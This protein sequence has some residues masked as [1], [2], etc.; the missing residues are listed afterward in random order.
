M[1]ASSQQQLPNTGILRTF[2]SGRHFFLKHKKIQVFFLMNAF[3]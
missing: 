1:I 3:S 2:F